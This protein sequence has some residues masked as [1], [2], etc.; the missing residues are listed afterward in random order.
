MIQMLRKRLNREEE[1]FTL[2]ELMVVVLII[3]ILL[4]IAIPTFLGART[5]AQNR[6]AESDL[7]TALTAEKTGFTDNQTYYSSA[8]QLSS[9]EPS[10]DWVTTSPSPVG[11]QVEESTFDS[12]AGVCLIAKSASGNYYGIVDDTNTSSSWAGT[13]YAGGS[14]VTCPS[15]ATGSVSPASPGSASGWYTSTTGA[16][17]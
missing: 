9:I 3:A 7:N 2:I 4:A 16:S 13:Y 14:S 1:G 11:N 15:G 10:L 6:A 12:G 5:R 8:A 17:W